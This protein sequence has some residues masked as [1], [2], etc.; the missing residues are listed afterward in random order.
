MP[1]TTLS[2]KEIDQLTPQDIAELANRLEKDDYQNAFDSLQDWHLLRAIGFQRPE[3]VTPYLH[4][5][6]VE[7]YDEA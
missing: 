3:L 7:A 6:D 5:L 1:T 4:L 2:A